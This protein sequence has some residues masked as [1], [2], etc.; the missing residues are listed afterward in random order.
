MCPDP[1]FIVASQKPII[2]PTK[3]S[4]TQPKVTAYTFAF[5]FVFF[6]KAPY[7]VAEAEF[8]DLTS[9]FLLL[10]HIRTST[11]RWSVFGGGQQQSPFSSLE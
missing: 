11:K 7:K 2:Q 10:S 1:A 8:H 3:P 6:F 4:S 5:F 9:L